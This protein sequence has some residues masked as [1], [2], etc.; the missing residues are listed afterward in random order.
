MNRSPSESTCF[1]N[2]AGGVITLQQSAPRPK[3]CKIRLFPRIFA[4]LCSEKTSLCCSKTSLCCSKTSLCCSKTPLCSSKKDVYEKNVYEKNVYE[5]SSENI[6][7]CANFP[8]GAFFPEKNANEYFAVCEFS[9]RGLFYR[10]K[11]FL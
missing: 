6:L 8:A 4:L 11:P 2:P 3:T 1:G 7:P 5:K 10:N 9:R